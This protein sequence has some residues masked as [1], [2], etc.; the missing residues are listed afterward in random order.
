MEVRRRELFTTIRTEG[1]ILPPDLLQRAAAGDQELGGLKPAD[2]HLIEGEPLNEAIVR[3]WNRLVGAWA[4]FKDA[5]E[6]LPEGDLGTTITRERWL[7]IL[8]DE[9]GYGRLQPARALEIEGKS[10]AVSHAWGEH[11]PIHLVGSKLLLDRRSQGVAGA[12]AMSPHG[13]VQELLN[14]SDERLW[15]FV[16]NGLTL[17]V[18]RDNSSLTRQAYVEFDLASMMDGDIYADFVVLW[19]VCHESRVEGDKP[20]ECWLEHWSQEAVKQGTRALNGLRTGVEAAISALGG[21]FLAHPANVEL[22]EGLRSGELD[23][24][25]YYRELLRL[26]YRLLFLLVA[27]DRSLLLDPDA[28]PE[29]TE[30]YDRFYS[31]R[32]LRRLA[33]RRRGSKHADIYQGLRFVMD[34]LG[35]D[36]GCPALGLPALGSY[37]WSTQALPNLARADLPNTALLDAVR[38]L[39]TLQERGVRR[40]VDYRNLGAEELGSVYESLL[41]LRPELNIDAGTFALTTTA[42]HERKTTGSYYTPTSLISC[43]LDSALDPVLAEAAEKG[44]EAILGLKV[45]DPACGSGHFLV[46]AAHRIA[47]RLA[48]ARTGD[49]EPSP[50]ATRTALRD[51]VGRCLYGVDMNPMAVELCKVSLWMEALEPGK[52]LSFLDAHVK[53]GNSLLGTT[54]A[55]MDGGIPDDAFKAITGDVSGV[56]SEWKRQNRTEREGQLT[57]EDLA[58]DLVSD[59]RTAAEALEALGDGTVEDVHGKERRF[60]ELAASDAF[61]RARL[62]ANVWCAAFVQ[63]KKASGPR[64]TTGVVRRIGSGHGAPDLVIES[65]NGLA[66]QYGFFHWEI[67]FPQV[68]GGDADG[69]DLVIGNPP[70]ERVKLQEKEFFAAY[71]DIAGARNAAERRRRIAGL[72]TGDPSLFAAYQE[73]LRKADGDSHFVRSSGR[74]PLCGRGDVNTFSIFAELMR[75]LLSQVGRVGC[76]LPLGIATDDTTKHFF[77]D[78]VESRSIASLFGFENEEFVFPGIDHRVTFGLLTVSGAERPCDEAEFAF[79]SRQVSA[80]TEPNRRYTLAPEDFA[81]LNP[82]TR[83]CPVFRTRRD[84]ELTKAIYRRVPVLVDE[85]RSDE[86]NPWGIKFTRMFDMAN[87]SEKF[88]TSEQL[89]EQGL[90][91][92]GNTYVRDGVQ[93]VP[94]YES[95]MFHQFDHR[96]GTYD[97]QTAAQANQGKLPELTDEDHAAAAHCAQPKYWVPAQLVSEHLATFSWDEE[98]LLSWRKIARNTDERTFISCVLPRFGVADSAISAFPSRGSTAWL[99]ANLSAY[100]FDFAVRQKLAGTN[101]AHFITKQLPVLPPSAYEGDVDYLGESVGEWIE[102][103]VLELVFTSYDLAAFANSIGYHGAPFRWDPERR[104]LLRAELDAGFFHLYGLVDED[105][106]YVMET[107][108]I[109]KRRDEEKYG[110]YRTKALILDGYRKMVSAIATGQQYETMLDPPPADPGIVHRRPA[111]AA[112]QAVG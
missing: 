104:V 12:A 13:L 90:V 39:A 48:S 54:V 109:V 66:T 87:D 3:S 29:A 17:R 97:G 11:V 61:A 70:W 57:L 14:R 106:D 34:K 101:M 76:V 2:Y 53:C 60:A 49:E 25:D 72:E 10:Y 32:R 74:Y 108:P 93:H 8:F 100:C 68:F 5:S 73:A 98:W 62:V 78:L 75:S 22:R 21:G 56:A 80:L 110:H 27:E 38:A 94:L 107:F 102:S 45:V 46:A 89:V 18:L 4:A 15:G 44:E 40:A 16:S 79:F 71:P 77:G 58:V 69:F 6:K 67:E 111:G 64:I 9:L 88:M 65:V 7:L 83:T 91:L 96:F 33:D 47:K 43:L 55:L 42:G 99:L 82:N 52:P 37:L 86:G 95:K 50:E 63:H 36:D 112:T 92:R 31:L 103:R 24:Q 51:V 35:N 28:S 30:R 84:A 1:A 85:S 41:E 26:V 19:L 59:L 105:I 20:H 81:L 23:K